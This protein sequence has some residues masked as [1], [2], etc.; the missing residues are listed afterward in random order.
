[1]DQEKLKILTA[2]KKG[3][4]R[5]LGYI[6]DLHRTA[7]IYFSEKLL[8]V[9]EQAEDIVGNSFMKLWTK[10]ADFDS[11]PAIKSFLYVVTRNACFDFLKYSKRVSAY[12]KDFSYWSGNREEEILHIMYEAEIIQELDREIESLPPKCRHIFQLSFYERLSACEIAG[13]LGL[14]VQTVR[15]QRAKAVQVLRTSFQKKLGCFLLIF[16]FFVC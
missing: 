15:N 13:K 8:G 12:Q 9:R 6:F 16:T 2:F 14:S 4:E 5:A 11:F 7:L 1:M 3:D 10:H